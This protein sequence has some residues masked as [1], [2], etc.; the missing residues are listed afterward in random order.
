MLC[1]RVV[2]ALESVRESPF[3]HAA[4]LVGVFGVM[5]IA[6]SIGDGGRLCV[7]SWWV[8]CPCLWWEWAKG[9]DCRKGCEEEAVMGVGLEVRLALRF[10]EEE[11][12]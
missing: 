9:S 1:F 10:E 7:A 8:C 2:F 3:F 5:G 4:M 6:L 11:D 12:V